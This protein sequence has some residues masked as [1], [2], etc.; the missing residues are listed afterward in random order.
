M[1]TPPNNPIQIKGGNSLHGKVKIQGSKNAALP[2]LAATLLI[3][4][5]CVLGNCPQITDVLYMQKLLEHAGCQVERAGD[6]IT[7]NADTVRECR[8]PRE[9]VGKMRSSVILMGALLGRLGRVGID[10]PGGC[11]IGE[12]PIDL[13][14]MALEKLGAQITTEGNYIYA[15]AKKLVGNE[16]FFPISSVGATQNALLAAVTAQGTTILH[17]A[18]CEPEVM[19]L[20]EF[21]SLAGAR[22]EGTGTDTLVIYGVDELHATEYE[23]IPDRIVAGTYLF[24]VMAAGGQV[25]LQNA[26]VAQLGAVLS[27]LTGMGASIITCTDQNT[28]VIHAPDRPVNL[29]YVE[30]EVYPGFPTDLQSLLLVAAC[31]AEGELVLRERIF[32]GRFKI[33]EEL[34]RMGA[35]IRQENDRAIIEGGHPLVGRNVIARELRG[36]AAL[37][38]AGL[39]ANG[40]TTVTDTMYIR[41][42]Y[43]DI[44]GDLTALGAVIAEYS[45]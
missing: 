23:I 26:P 10:Y 34:L 4:G 44:I 2:V 16:I 39:A 33:I 45:P 40:I 22:I 28:M 8:L 18:A 1:A 24:A 31:I 25:I 7:V 27:V 11:V 20:C 17:H 42:G 37:L 21:L 41:R 38:T 9:Y 14:L 5:S 36:G 12:R 29:P 30:T 6:K 15:T 3:R 19:A 35:V 32:S 43:E 13:H